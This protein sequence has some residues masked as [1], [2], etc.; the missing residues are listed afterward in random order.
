MKQEGFVA[1][2][3]FLGQA[4]L[5]FHSTGMSGAKVQPV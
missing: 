5:V 1:L 2:L 3:L 4:S